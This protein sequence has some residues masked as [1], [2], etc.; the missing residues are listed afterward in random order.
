MYG[1][2]TV[3]TSMKAKHDMTGK[4]KLPTSFSPHK[5]NLYAK[6]NNITG[7]FL[8]QGLYKFGTGDMN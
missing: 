7:K 5:T 1:I 2:E 4:F 6:Q 3:M 8:Y